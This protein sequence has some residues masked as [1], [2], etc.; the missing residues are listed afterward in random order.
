MLSG[1]F[2]EG[3]VASDAPTV[4]VL[5]DVTQCVTVVLKSRG[6]V[7]GRV[8]GVLQCDTGDVVQMCRDTG[9]GLVGNAAG[10][11]R[12]HRLKGYINMDLNVVGWEG[13]GCVDV[14]QGAVVNTVMNCRL[15]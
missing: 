10:R 15:A 13:L 4:R 7:E 5:L 12:L 9:V 14:A 6:A 11:R 8:C 2:G 1:T 3:H